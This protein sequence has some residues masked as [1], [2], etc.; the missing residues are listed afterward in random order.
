MAEALKHIHFDNENPEASEALLRCNT[1]TKLTAGFS[2][3]E[4]CQILNDML[5]AAKMLQPV[6]R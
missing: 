4:L 6:S 5:Q 3:P 2:R 1:Y